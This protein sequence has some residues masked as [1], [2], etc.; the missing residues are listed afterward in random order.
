MRSG[1][2]EAEISRPPINVIK[3]FEGSRRGVNADDR[4]KILK[5]QE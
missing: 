2:G 1:L 4:K 5:R 3:P